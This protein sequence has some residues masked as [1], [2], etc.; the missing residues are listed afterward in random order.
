MRR[1][2]LTEFDRMLLANRLRSR[3]FVLCIIIHYITDIALGLLTVI[4]VSL[5]TQLAFHTRE[6][7]NMP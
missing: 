3:C 5:S 6:Y 2:K 7:V 1:Q 4:D